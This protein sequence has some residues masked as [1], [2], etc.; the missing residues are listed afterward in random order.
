MTAKSQIGA[1]RLATAGGCF[2]HH[3]GWLEVA[4]IP[5]WRRHERMSVA[6]GPLARKSDTQD[7]LPMSSRTRT[8]IAIPRAFLSI[9]LL[10]GCSEAKDGT[11]EDAGPSDPPHCDLST[12]SSDAAGSSGG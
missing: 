10:F 12:S 4:I 8:R 3:C 2:R 5:R 7:E 11:A 6:V 9:P 1:T